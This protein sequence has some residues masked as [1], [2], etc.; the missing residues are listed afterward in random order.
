MQCESVKCMNVNVAFM[1][2]ASAE[3]QRA[4]NTCIARRLYLTLMS[5]MR[6]EEAWVESN[7]NISLHHLPFFHSLCLH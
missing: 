1:L 2:K 3:D 6:G 5:Q 4:C 7:Y